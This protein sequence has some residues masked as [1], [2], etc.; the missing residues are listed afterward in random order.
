MTAELCWPLAM[1]LFED[2]WS[3]AALPILVQGVGVLAEAREFHDLRGAVAQ[4]AAEVLAHADRCRRQ[5]EPAADGGCG[6]SHGHRAVS[7]ARR[8]PKPRNSKPPTACNALA[9]PASAGRRDSRAVSSTTTSR[10]SRLCTTNSAPKPRKAA[11]LCADCAGM[12]CGRKASMNSAT[13]GFS[14]LV[15]RPRRKSA[16][17]DTSGARPPPATPTSPTGSPAG[18]RRCAACRC[19]ATPGRARRPT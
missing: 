2:R 6:V 7:R 1:M 17:G 8:A 18:A 16:A 15:S 3:R 9:L 19:P 5:F 11:V 10:N 14:R 13:F 12:N 4:R